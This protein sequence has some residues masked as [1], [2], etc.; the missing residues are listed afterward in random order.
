MGIDVSKDSLDAALH[1][2]KGVMHVPNTEVGIRKVIRLAKKRNSELVCFEATGGYEMDLWMALTEAGLKPCPVNPRMTRHFAQSAG[3]LAKTDSIDAQVIADYAFAMKPRV[4]LFPETAGLRELAARRCQVQEMIIQENNRLRTTK[5]VSLKAKIQAHISW[6][7]EELANIDKCVRKTIE[8]NPE[9]NEKDTLLQTTPG[10]GNGLSNCLIACLPELG[11]LDRRKI[12][13]LV[14][15]APLNRDSGRFRG[16]RTIWGG[17]SSIRPIL[18][19]ATLTATMFNPTIRVFYQRL[20]EKGKN[21]KTA[22]VAC[23]RKLLT[24]L[25]AM[26]KHQEPWRA[27]QPAATA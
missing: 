19:M 27:L 18:Y 17:R 2:G 23:M 13:A 6:L 22:L 8:A 16:K 9:W 10:V 3:R 24:I 21:K 4:R 11:T 14:G 12:A 1:G 26:V 5:D 20:V 7:E 25:N 15:V